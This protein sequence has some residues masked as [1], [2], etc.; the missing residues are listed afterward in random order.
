MM[1]KPIEKIILHI[2]VEKTGSTSIQSFFSS[3]RESIY[4]NAN[5]LYSK[6]AGNTNHITLTAYSASN[7]HDSAFRKLYKI[8]S[9]EELASFRSQFEADLLSEAQK[10]KPNI[11][12]LSNEHLHSRIKKPEELFRL[13][14]FL[15][16]LTD[17]V[18]I[19]MYIRRQDKLAVSHYSTLVKVGAKPEYYLPDLSKASYHGSFL[20]Y[21]FSFYD[22][23]MNFVNVFG[24]GK[25]HVRVFEKSR[26]K[27]GDVVQDFLNF[28]G[29]ADS[30]KYRHILKESNQSLKPHALYVLR[31]LRKEFDRKD[32]GLSW[33]NVNLQKL[34][35]KLEVSNSG[36]GPLPSK[37]EAMDFYQNFDVQNRNLASALG[38][39]V[40]DLFD[41]NFDNYPAESTPLEPTFTD[42]DWYRIVIDLLG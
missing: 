9:E 30:S 29:I 12:V 2:G 4:Q 23:Y 33:S 14:N 24:D 25:V 35:R 16:I 27:N 22:I 37:K 28:I 39:S 10:K 41:Q 42:K 7:D 13:K 1:K 3:N 31:K 36:P 34:A 6:A 26:L 11:L 20:P 8:Q 32:S 21:Y 5:I 19:L 40:S 38:C 15:E 17:N 18:E